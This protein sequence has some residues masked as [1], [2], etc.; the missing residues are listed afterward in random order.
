MVYLFSRLERGSR[1]RHPLLAGGE[2]IAVVA[3]LEQPTV[4]CRAE[5]AFG[6]LFRGPRDMDQRGTN[7]RPI[8][9]KELIGGCE[10]G[11]PGNLTRDHVGQGPAMPSPACR[12]ARQGVTSRR[13]TTGA[14][15]SLLTDP[16]NF[17]GKE[18]TVNQPPHGFV[19][20]SPT[21]P[22]ILKSLSNLYFASFGSKQSVSNVVSNSCF[23]FC[24]LGRERARRAH[25]SAGVDWGP[26]T[27]NAWGVPSE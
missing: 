19:G 5:S 25:I 10:S 24:S 21:S 11:R 8:E 4:L 26:A 20:S 6:S 13:K 16:S 17:K 9:E 22:T 12:L 27:L 2:E 18:G 3:P 23:P 15:L 14:W 1:A 7:G